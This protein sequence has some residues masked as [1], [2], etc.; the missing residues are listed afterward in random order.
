MYVVNYTGYIY[1]GYNANGT[2]LGYVPLLYLANKK[3]LIKYGLI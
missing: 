2:K 1:T 3:L